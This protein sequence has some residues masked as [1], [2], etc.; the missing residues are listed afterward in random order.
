M[1]IIPASYPRFGGLAGTVE[2]GRKTAKTTKNMQKTVSLLQKSHKNRYKPLANC[3][4]LWYN[5]SA[6]NCDTR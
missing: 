6:C 3:K 4:K 5:Q 2:N 1:P